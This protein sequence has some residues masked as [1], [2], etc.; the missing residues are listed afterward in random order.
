MPKNYRQLVYTAATSLLVIAVFPISAQAN[1]DQEKDPCHQ[2]MCKLRLLPFRRSVDKDEYGI[3]RT[4]ETPDERTTLKARRMTLERGLLANIDGVGSGHSIANIFENAGEA[5]NLIVESHIRQA[6]QAANWAYNGGE[7]IEGSSISSKVLLMKLNHSYETPAQKD[8]AEWVA[9]DRFAKAKK[10]HEEDPEHN[11]PP[12]TLESYTPLMFALGETSQTSKDGGRTW[13]GIRF[14]T[15]LPDGTIQTNDVHVH[16]L[17]FN[18]NIDRQ[19]VQIGTLGVNLAY[20]ANYYR[21]NPEKF[22]HS[23]SDGLRDRLADGRKDFDIDMIR[24]D[25]AGIEHLKKKNLALDLELLGTGTDSLLIGLDAAHKSQEVEPSAPDEFYNLRFVLV[26]Q[27]I[28]SPPVVESAAFIAAKEKLAQKLQ[29]DAKEIVV[30]SEVTLPPGPFDREG[31]EK[32]IL[33]LGHHDH[34]A[35][36]LRKGSEDD[37]EDLKQIKKA[38]ARTAYI[39]NNGEDMDVIPFKQ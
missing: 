10:L 6:Q 28:G 11:P 7:P 36:L 29:V 38:G 31:T 17:L 12:Q 14:Q 19:K 39:Y 22:V 21:D 15:K 3:P 18:E 34:G 25:G 16:A 9:K 2:G 13:V 27:K 37:G 26:K 8:R 35:T 33:E 4:V 24:F 5:S 20:A 23:L 30:V 1:C 32:L